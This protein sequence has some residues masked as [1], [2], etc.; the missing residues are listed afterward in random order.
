M[1]SSPQHRKLMR[2]YQQNQN[3][4]ASAL[5]AGVDRKTAYKYLIEG[6]P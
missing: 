6:S 3:L 5:R 4:S 1:I 2:S